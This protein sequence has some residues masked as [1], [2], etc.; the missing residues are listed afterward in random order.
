MADLFYGQ[1]VSHSSKF[2]GSLLFAPIGT[3]ASSMCDIKQLPI[4]VFYT[5]LG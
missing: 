2:G 1:L 3:A 4:V 5:L